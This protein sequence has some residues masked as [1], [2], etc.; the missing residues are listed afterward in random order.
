M[1]LGLGSVQFGLDYGIANATGRTPAPEVAAILALAAERGVKVLDTAPSYGDSEAVVGRALPADQDF[2]IISKTRYF[3][4]A[5]IGREEVATLDSDFRASLE[6]LG[7]ERLYG[8]LLHHCDDLLAPGGERLW[9]AMAALKDR[10]LVAKIGVSVYTKRQIEAVLERFT[11][12]LVQLP[13]NVLDQRL[14]REFLDSIK[15]AG[16]TGWFFSL[17]RRPFGFFSTPF[18]GFVTGVAVS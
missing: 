4:L 18:T 7:V 8:L 2:R 15:R 1:N 5:K 9:A 10:G 17:P 13:L 12:D 3:R 11:I 16:I 14:S 6:R